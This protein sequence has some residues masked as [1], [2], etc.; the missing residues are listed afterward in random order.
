MKV[1]PCSMHVNIGSTQCREEA[2][3]EH[4]IP[5]REDNVCCVWSF[6]AGPVAITLGS[7]SPS[8]GEHV[9]NVQADSGMPV[10]YQL[11]AHHMMSTVACAAVATAVITDGHVSIQ[12]QSFKTAAAAALLAPAACCT[13]SS[14]PCLMRALLLV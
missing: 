7:A 13:S 4:V 8:S 10:H 11:R 9:I 12:L 2:P 14:S 3:V 6:P 1:L 5:T